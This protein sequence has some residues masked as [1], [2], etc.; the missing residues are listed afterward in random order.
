MMRIR[1]QLSCNE[2][3]NPYYFCCLPSN[4]IKTSSVHFHA[5]LATKQDGDFSSSENVYGSNSD[6]NEEVL[7]VPFDASRGIS[8]DA[9][10][11]AGA[12]LAESDEDKEKKYWRYC[13]CFWKN[14]GK[15][16]PIYTE[17]INKEIKF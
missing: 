17:P 16:A 5:N 14:C 2:S 15:V 9:N 13:C 4:M 11:D 7:H 8:D 6:G 3:K 10:A 1:A 12:E